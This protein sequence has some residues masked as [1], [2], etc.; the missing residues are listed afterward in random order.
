MVL[1]TLINGSNPETGL[2]L[3]M[4]ALP[5]ILQ[6][7]SEALLKGISSE[8]RSLRLRLLS[9]FSELLPRLLPPVRLH[10][11]PPFFHATLLTPNIAPPSLHH[12]GP[13]HLHI[14]PPYHNHPPFPLRAHLLDYHLRDPP[15]KLPP[16]TPLPPPL[17]TRLR[18][19]TIHPLLHPPAA[20]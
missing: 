2:P 20:N 10:H 4:K 5:E 8:D 13:K 17:K 18:P 9:F 1:Y 15:P 7:Y 16:L 3:V 11:S 12:L 14:H 19:K 6:R